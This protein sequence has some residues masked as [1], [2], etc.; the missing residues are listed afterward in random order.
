MSA[1]NQE[2]VRSYLG[3]LISVVDHVSQAVGKH[4]SDDD[5]KRIAAAPGVISNCHAVL[6]R[7]HEEL[8]ARL[9]AIGGATGGGVLKD[10]LTT[11]TGALAGLYGKMRGET[12]SRMI[13]DDYTAV[14]FRTACTTMLHTTALAVNDNAT[15]ELALRHIGQYQRVVMELSDLLPEAVMA[16]LVLDKVT[17]VHPN[18]AELATKQIDELWQRNSQPSGV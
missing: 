16:D 15:A 1:T 13:R 3:D 6:V 9:T 5:L 8:Q 10:M 18:A 7:Q 17:V 11:A 12:A 14:S 4:A 2:T